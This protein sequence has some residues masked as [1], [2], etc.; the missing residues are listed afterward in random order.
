MIRRCIR[1]RPSGTRISN[2]WNGDLAQDG[3]KVTVTN[4]DWNATLPGNQSTTFGLI[5]ISDGQDEDP[6]VAE[7]R[8][9][10]PR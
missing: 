5:A 1:S 10:G 9:F 8:T 4:L 7:C 3:D 6:P 2:L